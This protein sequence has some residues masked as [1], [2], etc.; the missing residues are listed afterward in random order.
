[1][2]GAVLEP[3]AEVCLLRLVRLLAEEI[4]VLHDGATLRMST[5]KDNCAFL[6]N[7]ANHSPSKHILVAP[8]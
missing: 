3:D 7:S 1:V 2:L 6:T 5:F 8:C 4:R